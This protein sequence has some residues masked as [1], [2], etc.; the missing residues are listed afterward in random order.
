MVFTLYT[1]T[2]F[3]LSRKVASSVSVSLQNSIWS[4]IFTWPSSTIQQS[5]FQMSI[6]C[7][8][9][10]QEAAPRVDDDILGSQLLIDDYSYVPEVWN[11][12]QW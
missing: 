12:F 7:Q 2:N 3:C 9:H 6:K 8:P 1:F 4:S 11:A 10:A 5:S